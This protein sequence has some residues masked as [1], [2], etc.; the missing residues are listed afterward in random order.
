MKKVKDTVQ[1]AKG[2]VLT[3][4]PSVTVSLRQYYSHVLGL[5]VVFTIVSF[6]ILL[7]I[8]ILGS[9]SYKDSFES[10][11]G[12]MKEYYYWKEIVRDHPD[13]HDGLIQAAR[14]SFALG[15][16]EEALDYVKQALIQDPNS[17]KA[18]QLRDLIVEE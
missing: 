1:K 18:L 12:T 2:K 8:L 6:V 7:A 11:R 3:L 10:S 13:F 17:E 5:F 9:K 16:K 15:N 14:Y 4:H